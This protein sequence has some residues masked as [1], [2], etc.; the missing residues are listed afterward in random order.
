[1]GADTGVGVQQRLEQHAVVGVR[2]RQ[3]GVQDQPVR[4]DEQV[5]LRPG[6]AAIGRVTSG[7][8][9]PLFALTETLSM[10]PRDQS[11]SWFSHTPAAFHAR[12]RR[13]AVCPDP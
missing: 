6:L 3:Q 8:L 10:Q 13:Q 5:V 1:M 12:S 9:A 2:R 7:E 11:I 4:V